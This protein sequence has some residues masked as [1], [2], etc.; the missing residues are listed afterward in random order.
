MEHI[1]GDYTNNSEEN[2][3]LLCPNCHSLTATYKGANKGHGRKG[4]ANTIANN[5]AFSVRIRVEPQEISK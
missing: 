1:V 4:E 5:V 2:L 3:I